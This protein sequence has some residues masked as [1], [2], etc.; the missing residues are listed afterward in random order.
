MRGKERKR[1]KERASNLYCL[2]DLNLF[3]K[4]VGFP[5]HILVRSGIAKISWT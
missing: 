1:E 5:G 2:N 3:S 4:F